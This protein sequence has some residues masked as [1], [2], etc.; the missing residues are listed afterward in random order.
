MRTAVEPA[1]SLAK[2]SALAPKAALEYL[3]AARC[4]TVARLASITMTIT[5]TRN[6]YQVASTSAVPSTRRRIAAKA[7]RIERPTRID[8]S[9]RA[10]RCSALPWP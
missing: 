9:A 2:W 8:A 5:M 10:D 7:I 4:E 3:R 6:A 1:R